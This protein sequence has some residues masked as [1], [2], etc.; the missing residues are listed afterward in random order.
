M[1]NKESSIELIESQFPDL[2][3]EL[4][5]WEEDGIHLQFGAFARFS[6]DAID[7]SNKSQWIKI[8]KVFMEIWKD[9][10]PYVKNALSVSFLA[11]LNFTDG[12]KR[13]SW[14]YRE[15]PIEMRMAWDRYEEYMSQFRM[16]H[17]PSKKK[18][19]QKINKSKRNWTRKASV[20][21]VCMGFR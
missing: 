10:S 7:E 16:H 2:T 15:M 19:E 8:T 6:Q 1:Y 14:A 3:P 5:D 17:E 13:R 4:N 20:D 12:K 11:D 18:S 9:C 21:S